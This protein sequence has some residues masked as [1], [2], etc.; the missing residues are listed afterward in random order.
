VIAALKIGGRECVARRCPLTS[1]AYDVAA[2]DRSGGG[3]RGRWCWPA[4]YRVAPCIAEPEPERKALVYVTALAPAEGE[5]VADFLLRLPRIRWP[6]S[7]PD[8][9]D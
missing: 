8:E 3:S 1:L 5:K 7:C 4:V 9:H 2:L 6:G